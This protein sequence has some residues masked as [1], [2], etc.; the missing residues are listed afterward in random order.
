M[1][2]PPIVFINPNSTASMTGAM[3]AAARAAAPD[4]VI[5]GRTSH[6]GPPAIQGEADGRLAVP[7]LLDIVR[8]VAD[9]GAGAIVIGCFD[10]TGLAEARA[11]APCPVI[12]LGQAAFHLAVL[13]ADRFSVVTTLAVSVPVVEGN[14]RAA[15]FGGKLGR[16]RASGIPVLQLEAQPAAS[17]DRLRDE[18]AAAGREDGIGAVVLGC[19]GMCVLASDLRRTTPLAVI[20]GVEAAARLA[21]ILAGL[22]GPDDRQA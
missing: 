21:P 10:D 20:D 11:L 4:A 15:G 13:A 19:A 14:I 9:A 2:G 5:E 17:L 22:H 12:G 16:V 8:E 3:V 1:T 6:R 18:I 7:P